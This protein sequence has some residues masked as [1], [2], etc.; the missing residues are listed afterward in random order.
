MKIGII[1]PAHN[2]ANYIKKT[3]DSLLNQS[4]LPDLL[5]VV[6]DNSTDHTP[7]IIS[8][9][10]DQFDWIYMTTIKSSQSRIPGAKVID[11]WNK[12]LKFIS[13]C[14]IMCKFDADLIFPKNYISELMKRFSEDEKL[15]VFGGILQILDNNQKWVDE[16]ISDSNHVRGPLKAYK[17]KCLHEIGGLKSSLGWDTVDV[18]LAQYHGWKTETDIHLKVKHLRPTGSGYSPQNQVEIFYK[19]RYGYFISMLASLKQKRYQFKEIVRLHRAYQNAKLNHKPF[20]VSDEEGIFI[21]KIR[22]KG[23]WHKFFKLFAIF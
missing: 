21:R 2:E 10:T 9:Y 18:L 11:A 8:Q 23:I 16:N 22:W 7:E 4:R 17:K 19:L 14:D 3:L 13:N 15:G 20:L 12:G 5:C 6:D 1:I